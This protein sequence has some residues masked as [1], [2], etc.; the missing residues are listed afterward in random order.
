MDQKN[1]HRYLFLDSLRGV[2]IIL[3][4]IFHFSYDLAHY[5]LVQIDFT[6]DFFWYWF[7]RLIAFLFIFCMGVS[8]PLAHRKKVNWKKL[9]VRLLKLGLCAAA[10]SLVTYIMF[11]KG[12][13][14]F[15]V[16][17]YMFVASV[18]GLFFV[19]RPKLS[20][21]AGITMLTVHFTLWGTIGEYTVIPLSD[22]L[23]V[24]SSDYIPLYPW[25]AITCLGIFAFQ[26]NFHRILLPDWPLFRAFALLGRHSLL[27]YMIHQPILFG[28]ATAIHTFKKA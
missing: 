6:R 3:M 26:H 20:L 1:K 25:F 18:L 7:A 11:P 14:Y 9:K 24:R 27:L 15:G 8:L 5:Q 19:A 13:I 16:L 17:H 23:Q 10:V 28:V 4:A 21:L 12:W 2:A 22:W